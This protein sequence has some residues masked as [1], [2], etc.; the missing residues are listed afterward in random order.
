M[1]PHIDDMITNLAKYRV[2]STFD[3]KN[4]Y[5]QFLIC[6]SD[7]KYTGFEANGRLYQFHRIPFVTNDVAVCQTQEERDSNVA[8]FL[9]VLSKRNLTWNESNSVLHLLPSPFS[10][11]GMHLTYIYNHL[12]QN[13]FK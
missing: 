10:D 8:A 6:D 12:L 11:M 7:K 2:Y 13:F 1:L 5:H 4:A 9:K 3:L